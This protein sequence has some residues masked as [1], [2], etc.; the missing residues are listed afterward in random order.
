MNESN[1]PKTTP[2]TSSELTADQILDAALDLAQQ[3]DNWYDFNLTDLANH[4]DTSINAIRQHYPDTNAIANAWFAR[5]LEAMLVELDDEMQ[6]LP[7]KSRLE[8]IVWRWFEALAP[9]HRLSAQMLGAKLHPPHVHHWVPMIFDLSQLVQLWRDAAG[10]HTGGRR[11][12]IE[13]I[14]LTSI[15][16]RTLCSWCRDNSAEQSN[17]HAK[18]LELLDKA[19]RASSFWFHDQAA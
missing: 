8:L 5:A 3:Q 14:V 2:P 15:F 6:S 17:S 16:V 1:T 13:E 12:Q 19:D 9:Y 4:C 11:R 18:L 7:V 10:L